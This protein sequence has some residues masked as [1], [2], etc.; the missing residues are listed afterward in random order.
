MTKIEAYGTGLR[1]YVLE[2][3]RHGEDALITIYAPSG[4]KTIVTL[5]LRNE[6]RRRL[7]EALS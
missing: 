6:E 7:V 3:V 2:V 4:R 1:R 5:L